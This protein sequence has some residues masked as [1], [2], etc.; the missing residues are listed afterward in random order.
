VR[1]LQLGAPG[2]LYAADGISAGRVAAAAAQTQQQ[3]PQALPAVTTVH[4]SKTAGLAD[5][6]YQLNE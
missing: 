4:E 3:T 6:P 5:K 1:L 2:W